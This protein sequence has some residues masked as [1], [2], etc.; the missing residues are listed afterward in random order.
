MLGIEE[1]LD[2]MAK[3]SSMR[4]YG[5]VLRKE[6]ENVILKAFKFELRGSRG[7]GRPKQRRKKQVQ[8]EMKKNGLVKEDA[9]DQRKWQAW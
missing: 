9:C 5:H 7:R 1:S 8:N 6:D 3:V 2:T 4:W